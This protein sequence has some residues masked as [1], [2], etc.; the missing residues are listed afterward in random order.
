MSTTG[1]MYSRSHS[2]ATGWAA[3]AGSA[4]F[5]TNV[6]IN[7]F[8]LC[9]D[10][11]WADLERL[12][13]ERGRLDRIRRRPAG[14]IFPPK[15]ACLFRESASTSLINRVDPRYFSSTLICLGLASSALAIS[16]VR[17]PLV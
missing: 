8:F 3:T 6:F 11:H 5:L 10:V 16:M 12:L 1:R 14:G 15:L 2:T 9:V 7:K 17:T 13:Q 4:F